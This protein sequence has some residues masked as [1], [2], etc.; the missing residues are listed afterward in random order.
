[1]AIS[2]K[3]DNGEL[4]YALSLHRHDN[5]L[6]I[7]FRDENDLEFAKQNIELFKK[8]EVQNQHG[9]WASSYFNFNTL[10]KD[11]NKILILSNNKSVYEEPVEEI[12]AEPTIEEVRE[13]KLKEISD[14]CN[15][16]IEI[17][18]GIEIGGVD[19]HFTYDVNDQTN[20]KDAFDLAVQTGM[21]VPYH[22]DN[23]SCKLYT[24]E[25]ITKLYITEKS[26]LTHHVTYHNQL[27][28]YV[29]S[30]ESVDDINAVYYGMDLPE[31]YQEKYNEIMAQASLITNTV[32]L[33]VQQEFSEEE[34]SADD[35][36]NLIIDG[37]E[38]SDDENSDILEKQ[39]N[40]TVEVLDDYESDAN[41]DESDDD[42]K[43]DLSDEEPIS[44]PNESN[45]DEA[46]GDE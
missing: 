37:E 41:E 24:P 10:W 1:M 40:D 27:K 13:N 30:L 36:D 12:I 6:E 8:I 3:L 34:D 14:A 39:E 7:E 5:L 31:E 21:A 26:N 38:K 17:G 23:M 44:I 32:K 22:A 43:S 15:H 19:E 4:Y 33:V 45:S 46:G 20:I 28:M 35:D 25:Q 9:L 18:V 29:M 11:D 42:E 2:I 16:R